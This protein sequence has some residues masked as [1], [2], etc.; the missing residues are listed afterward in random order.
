MLGLKGE[1]EIGEK[2][3]RPRTLGVYFPEISSKIEDI[4]KVTARP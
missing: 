3:W 2:I 1:G 4:R